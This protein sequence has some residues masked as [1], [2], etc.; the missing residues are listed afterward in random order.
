M[1]KKG[2][3]VMISGLEAKPELNGKCGKILDGPL[4]SGRCVSSLA[5]R[6]LLVGMHPEMIAIRLGHASCFH[7]TCTPNAGTES[8]SMTL[9]RWST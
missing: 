4:D 2:D 6:C 7:H 3:S 8:E 5:C 1:V 9:M